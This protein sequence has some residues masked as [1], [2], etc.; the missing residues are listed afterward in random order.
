MD[1]VMDVSNKS[2][3]IRSLEKNEVDFVLISVL[4]KKLKV[5]S[6]DLMSNQ[7]FLVGGR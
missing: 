3:V 4:P 5:N 7:L 6:V 1:L 2:K